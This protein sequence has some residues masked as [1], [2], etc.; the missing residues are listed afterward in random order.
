MEATLTLTA[1]HKDEAD[2][3]DVQGLLRH[4]R[5][6]L[7]EAWAKDGIVAQIDRE[8]LSSLRCHIKSA[9]DIPPAAPWTA[10]V[11]SITTAGLGLGF[12]SQRPG[13]ATT[14]DVYMQE[15]PESA[16]TTVNAI[17]AELRVRRE[18]IHTDL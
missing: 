7:R 3:K 2:L 11:I 18:G 8:F 9:A 17:N 5:L 6:D 10:C 15:I 1:G 14:T 12:F 16:Q 13:A 4:F